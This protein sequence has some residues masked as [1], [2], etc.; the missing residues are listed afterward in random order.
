MLKGLQNFLEFV[1]NNWTSI[2]VIIGLIIGLYKKIESFWKLSTDQKVAIAK[3]EIEEAMLKMITDSELEYETWRESGEIKR[4][5][6][7]KQIYAEYPILE[8]VADQNSVI[9]WID[10]QIDNALVT[11]RKVIEENRTTKEAE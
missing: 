3:H 11:L 4:S 2:L 7:I 10:T 6:V 8:K 5:Q 9:A 1:N